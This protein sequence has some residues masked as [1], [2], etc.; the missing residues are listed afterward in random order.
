MQ[1]SQVVSGG[2]GEEVEIGSKVVVLKTGEGK[3]K[4][5]KSWVQKRLTW[6]EE[7]FPTG[8]HLVWHFLER[9]KGENV[10]FKTPSGEVN[11]KIINVS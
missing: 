9:K 1:E 5:T 7:R 2:G 6:P 8:L 10:S 11:Y 3:E 4:L